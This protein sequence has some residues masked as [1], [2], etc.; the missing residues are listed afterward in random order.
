MKCPKCQ[1]DTT[2]TD[3]RRK[4]AHVYR[5]RV[6][7]SCGERCTTQETILTGIK[8]GPK[9]RTEARV[10][11][12]RQTKQTQRVQRKPREDDY[13]PFDNDFNDDLRELGIDFS[14]DID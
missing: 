1:A 10:Q 13:Q 4:A 2:V 12:V 8:R 3:S 7:L 5:R 6:C 9:P 11:P 14:Q